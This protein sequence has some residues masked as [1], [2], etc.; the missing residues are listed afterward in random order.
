MPPDF[1]GI[2]AQKAATSWIY[3]CLYEHPQI[4]APIKELNFF[5]QTENW[6]KGP[7]WYEKNWEGQCQSSQCK[8]EFGTGYLASPIAPQRIASLYPSVKLIVCLRHPVDRAISNYINDIKAGRLRAGT[9]FTEAIKSHPEYLRQGY[10]QQQLENY[11]KFFPIHHFHICLYEDIALNPALFMSKIYTFL[12]VDPGFKSSFLD[13]KINTAG[14]PNQIWLEKW[15]NKLAATL[16]RNSLGRMIWWHIK[17]S[18]LP[19]FIRKQNHSIISNEKIITQAE[20]QSLFTKF[21]QD[22]QYLKKLI[23]R[24]DLPWY[25]FIKR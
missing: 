8:G 16:Q 19:S 4:C 5:N 23:K 20:Y 17:K 10:Y 6:E 2:G 12:E 24:K 11:F 14:I 15:S 18:G 7:T 25:G 22:I 1:I 3:A 13:K 21:E 9:P